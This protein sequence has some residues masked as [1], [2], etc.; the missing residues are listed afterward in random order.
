MEFLKA[1]A[2]SLDEG[3]PAETVMSWMRERYTTVRCLNV[4]TCL[5]RQLCNPSPEYV[6]ARDALL[7]REEDPEARGRLEDAC[8]SGRSNDPDIKAKLFTLPHR[9]PDNVYALRVTRSE[10]RECKKLASSGKLEKNRHRRRVDGRALL[11]EARATVSDASSHSVIDLAMALMLVTGRRTCEVLNGRSCLEREDAHVIRFGGQ[12]K[13]RGGASSESYLVPTLAHADKVLAA[14]AVLRD[15]QHHA[16]LTNRET[17]RRYQSALSHRLVQKGGAWAGVGCIHGLRGVYA[18]MALRL[19]RWEGDESDAFVTMCILG[20]RDLHESLVY[21]PFHLGD[22][23]GDE[24][25][26]GIGKL[27]PPASTP[28]SSLS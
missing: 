20:H 6:V 24:P 18:C 13:R 4:K 2:A 1:C 10:M 26:L 21:T 15:K 16:Q 14:L 25:S 17:S 23:F 12:A 28:T 11:T 27:T 9:L 7:V 5:V 19:L 8:L 3:T 22:D